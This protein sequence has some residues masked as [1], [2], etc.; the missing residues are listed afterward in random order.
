LNIINTARG[1]DGCERSWIRS[2][3]H[4]TKKSSTPICTTPYRNRKGILTFE[5]NL[6]RISPQRAAIY[7][8]FRPRNVDLGYEKSRI[9]TFQHP[10]NP[11][12]EKKLFHITV[13]IIVAVAK[14]V[15]GKESNI[16]WKFP[17]E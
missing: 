3:V 17:S 7:F 1:F 5:E 11:E 12:E 15:I 10:Y 8:P 6:F 14:R 9:S 2:C 4:T 16:P 13:A